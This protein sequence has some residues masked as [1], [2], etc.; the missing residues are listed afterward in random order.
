[1]QVLQYLLALLIVFISF[2]RENLKT[3]DH[4]LLVPFLVSF[5]FPFGSLF[6]PFGSLG[7]FR[8]V[9]FRLCV[10][11]WFPLGIYFSF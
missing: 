9:N 11:A 1:M 3:R 6:G 4:R 5:W 10:A 8:P 2:D 7:M